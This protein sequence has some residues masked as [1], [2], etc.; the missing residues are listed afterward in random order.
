MKT[1][2]RMSRNKPFIFRGKGSGLFQIFLVNSVLTIL[3]LGIYYFWA[4]VNLL[5]YNYRNSEF[6]GYSFSYHGSGKERLLGFLRALLIVALF[7]GICWGILYLAGKTIWFLYILQAIAATLAPLALIAIYRYHASRTSYRNVRFHFTGKIRSLAFLLLE[8]G[9]LMILTSGLY[10]PA[11]P[12]RIKKYVIDHLQYG[13]ES[14]SLQGST[15]K[16]W[17]MEVLA[18]ILML[19]TFGVYFFWWIAKKKNFYWNHTKIQDASFRSD[20][21]GLSVLKAFTLFALLSILT[22]GLALPWAITYWRKVQLEAL[23]VYG[24]IDFDSIIAKSG[25]KTSLTGAG[26]EDA[27]GGASLIYLARIYQSDYSVGALLRYS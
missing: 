17:T 18:Y 11:I 6:Q 10:F 26:L 7:L 4:R 23:Q 16:Y 1:P 2:Q 19:F 27:V 20:L 15:W 24:E 14:F 21:S 25:G 8:I 9:V 22:L 13:N 5:K 3:S 12:Y